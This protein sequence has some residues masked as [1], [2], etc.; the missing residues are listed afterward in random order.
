MAI[1]NARQAGRLDLKPDLGGVVPP[2]GINLP[3]GFIEPCLPTHG[4]SVPTGPQWAYEIKHDGYRFICRRDGERVRVFSRRGNDHTDRA[5]A[6]ADALWSAR[7]PSM[8]KAWSA[9]LMA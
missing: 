9:V 5:P 3:A 4:R 6:I 8:A 1:W 2:V 7:S